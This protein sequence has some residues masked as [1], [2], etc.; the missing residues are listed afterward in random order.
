[1]KQ[2]YDRVTLISKAKNR[3]EERDI[4]IDDFNH[5]IQSI[6]QDLE[7]RILELEMENESIKN[8]ISK[9]NQQMLESINGINLSLI[10]N[11]LAHNECE[12]FTAYEEE[13]IGTVVSEKD[14][15]FI[16][17]NSIFSEMIG[18]EKDELYSK[19]TTDF[20]FSDDQL[21]ETIL[22]EQMKNYDED[23]FHFQKRYIKK[24]GEI[25]WG[26]VTITIVY[27]S[28]KDRTLFVEKIKDISENK[29]YESDLKRKQHLLSQISE[30]LPIKVFLYDL[31]ES[32]FLWFNQATGNFIA[33]YLI[34]NGF[35]D[36]DKINQIIY[37]KDKD[38]FFNLLENVKT[39]GA[40]GKIFEA[41]I[42]FLSPKREWIWHFVRMKEFSRDDNGI[43]ELLCVAQDI[44]KL[45]K[46]E[47]E[48][49]QRNEMYKILVKNIQDIVWSVDLDG[50][51]TYI[52]PSIMKHLGYRPEELIGCSFEEVILPSEH[53]KL[54]NLIKS[55]VSILNSDGGYFDIMVLNH[56]HKNGKIVPLEVSISYLTN[57][58]G[59]LLGLTGITRDV[60]ERF[61]SETI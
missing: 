1:M 6:F 4:N 58:A 37:P 60:S 36:L 47:R 53:K 18:Y 26:E 16:F 22:I 12:F 39:I 34:Q 42:R 3:L 61:Y 48:L 29:K 43:K 14:G 57:E 27:D 17:V 21:I 41:E 38:R 52:T 35:F 20:I 19:K 10:N 59:T 28:D 30:T 45:K 33:P 44:S 11:A 50:Y 9:K 7:M 54:S 49:E 13:H 24:S 8:R 51:F 5:Q 25:L 55:D 15:P 32:R 46:T 40:D 23:T 31:E 2:W 56:N